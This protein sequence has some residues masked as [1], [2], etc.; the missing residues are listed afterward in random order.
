MFVADRI[1]QVEAE[2]AAQRARVHE[3][4]VRIHCLEAELES[5]RPGPLPN[6][7]PDHGHTGVM[8][9]PI[10]TVVRGINDRLREVMWFAPLLSV[11]GAGAVALVLANFEIQGGGLFGV[12][13]DPDTARI[14]LSTAATITITFAGLVFAI[15]LLALQLTS[16]QFSPRVLRQFLR[17]REGQAPLGVFAATFV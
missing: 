12:T 6:P 10:P 1:A 4:V 15:T 17:A 7:G 8:R 16:S 13:D 11:I 2:L 14:L 5:L 9:L 3:E